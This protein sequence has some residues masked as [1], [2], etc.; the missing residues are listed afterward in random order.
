MADPNEGGAREFQAFLKS[1]PTID[2]AASD[3]SVTVAGLAFRSSDGKFALT[4]GEGQTYDLDIG[5][6]Q[7]FKVL[8]SSG[9]APIVAIQIARDVFGKATLRPLK[10][11]VKD[12]IKDIIKD[13]IHDHKRPWK[14]IIKDP[15]RDTIKELPKDPIRDTFKEIPKDP[16]RDTWW[17]T[18][19][20]PFADPLDPTGT[21]VADSAVEQPGGFD[22]GSIVNPAVGMGG[23]AM[24]GGDMTPFIMATPH[25]APDFLVSQQMGAQPAMAQAAA[26][27][28]KP[29]ASDTAKELQ[30]ETLYHFDRPKAVIADT[31]KE[32]IFDTRKEM[33]WE[34]WVEGGPSWQ[35]NTFDPGGAV[36]Q[37]PVWGFPGHMM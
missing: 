7:R 13:I 29:I 28:L 20:Q 9:L 36:T 10:P 19:K 16:I 37:P 34:T 24:Q 27:G 18:H 15:I 35:E 1:V 6:V 21:G 30:Y 5:A 32:M 25:Q 26:P 11:V 3:E 14:D 23:M 8:D 17:E 12:V 33:I 31:R 4:T 22:P 2:E